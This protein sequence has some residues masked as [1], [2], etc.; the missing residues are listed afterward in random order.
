MLLLPTVNLLEHRLP[1]KVPETIEVVIRINDSDQILVVAPLD[2]TGHGYSRQDFFL[3]SRQRGSRHRCN[4]S[5]QRRDIVCSTS[6]RS[7][8]NL[9]AEMFTTKTRELGPPPSDGSK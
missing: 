4:I 1:N 8:S 3:R 9:N 7:I 5:T 2:P 6:L